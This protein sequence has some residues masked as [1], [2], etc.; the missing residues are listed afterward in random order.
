MWQAGHPQWRVLLAEDPASQGKEFRVLGF[1]LYRGY[2]GVGLPEKK[3]KLPFW[4]LVF[5]AWRFV[6]LQGLWSRAELGSYSR[7][8][9]FGVEGSRF[10]V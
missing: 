6:G 3:W 1:G 9:G 10:R 7:V 8:Q 4:S 5:R 2:M